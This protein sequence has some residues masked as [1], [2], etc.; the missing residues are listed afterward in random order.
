[1]VFDLKS[2]KLGSEPKGI[3]TTIGLPEEESQGVLDSYR[4]EGSGIKINVPVVIIYNVRQL[5]ML[6]A[7]NLKNCSNNG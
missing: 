1:M 3:A 4:I 7:E 2:L 6:I 5:A